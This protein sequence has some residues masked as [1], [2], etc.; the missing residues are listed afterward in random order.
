MDSEEII[1]NTKGARSE[2]EVLECNYN[3]S[4]PI[5][6]ATKNPAVLANYTPEQL[7][8]MG[9]Q[10]DAN[11]KTI[12]NKTATCD[13][14]P[15][16]YDYSCSASQIGDL[17]NIMGGGYIFAGGA[18]GS[19]FAFSQVV[20][21]KNGKKII[22][23][24]CFDPIKYKELGKLLDGFL[25]KEMESSNYEKDCLTEDLPSGQ[26]YQAVKAGNFGSPTEYSFILVSSGVNFIRNFDM[27]HVAQVCDAVSF[28]VPFKDL[29]PFIKKDGVL[30]PFCN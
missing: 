19:A 15:I 12:K 17:L 21:L 2:T 3:I 24:D 25:V 4:L 22:A 11:Y 5:L 18:H 16:D 8:N 26:K 6:K 27:P 7:F 1:Y 30:V 9:D 28:V 13:E 20:N 23:A 10:V 14:F 29:A